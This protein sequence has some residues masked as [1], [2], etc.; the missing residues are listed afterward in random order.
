M[1]GAVRQGGPVSLG[2]RASRFQPFLLVLL[3]LCSPSL[4]LP[5]APHSATLASA[6]G[7]ETGPVVLK[8]PASEAAIQPLTQ[9]TLR[10]HIDGHPR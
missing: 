8:H 9:V 1:A 5:R 10:C 3:P 7:L 6:P 4:A 2:L